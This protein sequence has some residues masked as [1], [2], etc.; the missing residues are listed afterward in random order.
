MWGQ[1]SQFDM[2][3]GTSGMSEAKMLPKI[4]STGVTTGPSPRRPM[5]RRSPNQQSF[6][7]QMQV[8]KMPQGAM[9]QQA[10]RK[11]GTGP[12]LFPQGSVK[13]GLSAIKPVPSVTTR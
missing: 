4:T 9:A 6:S 12:A 8:S 13:T 2:G 3:Q 7:H 5:E 10:P 1:D 11:V